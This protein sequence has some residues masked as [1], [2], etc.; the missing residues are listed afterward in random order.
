[1][2]NIIPK[3]CTKKAL[4]YKLF[5]HSDRLYFCKQRFYSLGTPNQRE[6]GHVLVGDFKDNGFAFGTAVGHANFYTGLNIK[7]RYL[8]LGGENPPVPVVFHG[9]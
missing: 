3:I 1:M 4:S 2:I 6:L 9:G 7:V 5:F 8:D